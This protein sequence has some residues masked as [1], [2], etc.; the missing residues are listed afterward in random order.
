[1][2][3]G[4]LPPPPPKVFFRRDELVDTVVDFTEHF[5]SMALV[6]TGG[7]GKTSIVLTVLE[8]PRIKQR[9]GD[10]WSFIRCDR[11]TASHTH[12]LRKLSEVIGAGVENPE[13]LSPMRRYLSSKKMIVVLNN[14]ESILGLAETN[15][16]EI[17]TIVDELSQFGNICLVITSRIS[18]ALP[19]HCEII[20]IPTLSMEAGQ[21]TF[22]RIYRL[23]GRSD[24]INEI[25][26]ELDSHPLSITLLAIVSQQNRWNTKRLT[27]EWDRQRTGVLRTRNL[28][29]LA[30]AIELSL[31][32]PMFQE[33]GPDAREVLGVVAFF[34]QGVN[35]DNVEGLFP[36]ISDGPSTF[37]TLCNLSLTYRSTGFITMLAPLRDYLRP[38][39]PM[40]SPLL[41]TARKHYSTRLLVELSPGE[42]GFEETQWITLEDAN[43]E[44]LLNIFTSI[45]ADSEDIWIVC[46][47]FVDHLC[48]H[49]PRLVAL[50]SK[51]EA[52]PDGHPL[53]SYCLL[54]LSRLFDRVGNWR[55]RKRMLIQS[56]RLF[57]ERRDDYL[58]AG[59][60]IGLADANRQM[61]LLGEGI[62]QVREALEIFVRLGETGQ[63]SVCLLSLASL[64]STDKQLD[65]AEEAAARAMDLLENRDQNQLCQYHQVLGEI[66]RSKGNIEEAIHHFEAS[67]RISSSLNI[68]ASLSKTH[69]ALAV[70]YFEEKKFN[71]AHAHVEHAKSHV[72]NGTFFQGCVFSISARVLSDQNRPEE[73]KSEASHALAIFEKLGATN[74]VGTTTRLLENIEGKI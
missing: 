5:A 10:S 42:P 62:R 49:K 9:F 20:E 48:W 56:L 19:T 15:A 58:I 25:L 50:G 46:M 68:H 23:G 28:G 8:D 41:L 27:T 24:E 45:D 59:T 37:D 13:D 69:L 53:K 34:P 51:I 43:V 26:R 11:L 57:R 61:D 70:L 12:F 18:N 2:P 31:A 29:S 35:E 21:E 63:Q 3:Q 72:G 32:S 7:I 14:A 36:T 30:A 40:A 71:D 38:E 54:S 1:M 17:H 6:G 39:D 64:L 44:H 66:H 52:L 4:E 65:A 74:F 33:L 22:Y 60:L 16:Q 67:L 55:E 73:A 47:A